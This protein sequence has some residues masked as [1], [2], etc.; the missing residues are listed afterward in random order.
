VKSNGYAAYD[1]YG[2]RHLPRHL[3]RSRRAET[4]RQLLFDFDWLVAKLDATDANALAADCDLLP[5]DTS[6][7]LVQGAL[8]LST[9]ALERNKNQL[10]GQLLG[11]LLGVEQAGIPHLLR[12]AHRWSEQPWLEPLNNC[13]VGPQGS[14]IRT[15]NTGLSSFDADKYG[16]DLTD[17]LVVTPDGRQAVMANKRGETTVIDLEKGAILERNKIEPFP[18]SAERLTLSSDG[19]RL[20]F[21]HAE[22]NRVEVWE[23]KTRHKLFSVVALEHAPDFWFTSDGKGL[24]Y[25][26][27]FRGLPRVLA[28]V[29]VWIHLALTPLFYPTRIGFFGKLYALFCPASFVFFDLESGQAVRNVKTRNLLT[30]GKVSITPDARFAVAFDGWDEQ[31]KIFDLETGKCI[32]TIVGFTTQERYQEHSYRPYLTPAGMQQPARVWYHKIEH[33]TVSVPCTHAMVALSL[34]TQ[35]NVKHRIEIWDLV[36]EERIGRFEAH[37]DTIRALAIAPDGKTAISVSEDA[38]IAVWDLR[39]SQRYTRLEGHSGVVEVAVVTD[40]GTRVVSAGRDGTLRIWDLAAC[41]GRST[42]PGEPETRQQR[43]ALSGKVACTA[44][45][46][47]GNLA[48]FGSESGEISVWD[49]RDGSFSCRLQETGGAGIR[50]LLVTPDSRRLVSV[51][52]AERK[53]DDTLRIVNPDGTLTVPVHGDCP[54]K[55]WNLESGNKLFDLGFRALFRPEMTPDGCWLFGIVYWQ[56]EENL[57]VVELW[58]L[59]DGTALP[60]LRHLRGRPELQQLTPDSR[61]IVQSD[62]VIR[63]WVPASDGTRLLKPLRQVLRPIEANENRPA[64]PF[65]EKS[66]SAVSRSFSALSLDGRI[67]LALSAGIRLEVWDLEQTALLAHFEL[68]ARY[69]SLALASDGQSIAVG[70]TLGGIYLLRLQNVVPGASIVTPWGT[71]DRSLA[72][73]CPHCRAWSQVEPASLGAELSCPSCSH[74]IRLNP[75]TIDADWRPVAKA[76]STE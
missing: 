7:Q 24:V 30:D 53:V 43:S 63:V 17:C 66:N 59:Q 60:D 76:W 40:D 52:A 1:E 46:P 36:Q 32:K 19:R 23:L 62:G 37:K 27:C 39:A 64:H 20:A 67:G 16:P 72:F 71:P 34:S 35:V 45:T 31:I 65:D 33:I 57:E 51:S 70:D 54:V 11:R 21:F 38:S 69:S 47:D 15:I 73:G 9:S 25:L 3:A 14:L 55:V 5:D 42:A 50:T 58:N 6:L 74:P 12:Q 41:W 48:I 13:L 61:W 29:L 56:V 44:F 68:D 22:R 8:R 49:M 18:A 26:N 10:A 4:L 2:F 75:F 28:S